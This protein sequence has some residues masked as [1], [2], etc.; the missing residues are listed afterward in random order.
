VPGLIGPPNWLVPFPCGL[1][2]GD[3]G[4]GAHLPSYSPTPRWMSRPYRFTGVGSV[5]AGARWSVKGLMPTNLREHRSGH[6][7]REAYYKGFALWLAKADFNAQ[8]MVECTGN[9]KRWWI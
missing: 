4:F 5:S 9:F 6:A 2:R 1:R 8:L 3:L 7:Q